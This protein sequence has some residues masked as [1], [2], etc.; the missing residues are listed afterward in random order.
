M[1]GRIEAILAAICAVTLAACGQAQ[2]VNTKA[3]PPAPASALTVHERLAPDYKAVA[4]VITNRD[5]GDAR[6]RIG[7]RLSQ[8]LVREGDTV[9]K[10][11]LVAMIADERI[12][13]EARAAVAGQVAAQASNDQSQRDLARAERLFASQAIAQAAIEAART[14]A[15]AAAASLRA[16]KAQADA[17]RALEQQGE[18]RAPA[19]GK[20]LH[21]TIPQGS[22]VM[23]GDLVVS[24]STG[25]QVLRIELPE[26]EGKSLGAGAEIALAFEQGGG[27]SRP[28]RIRQVY[29]AVSN[30][31][32][33]A[34]LDA[35][36][37]DAAF[38]GARVRV[39]VPV[40]QRRAIVVPAAYIDTR[41]GADYVRLSRAGSAIDVPVQLGAP[42]P[43]P[44]MSD[45]VEVLS[46]LRD[47]DVILPAGR[48]Q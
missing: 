19:D 8:L 36:G 16:T 42:L 4:A 22:N 2:T 32:I 47:G 43:L 41:Y 11:Q 15:Q 12:A 45:G 14:Q 10:N 28:A 25:A 26:S 7:G 40:G 34:D 1:T 39:L 31:R 24:I 44:D 5:A 9:K 13:S 20:V 35:P 38:I 46:G 30:G 27:A 6:A 29:P 23:P 18:V 48:G 37:L 17:A 3:E 33:T 21:A